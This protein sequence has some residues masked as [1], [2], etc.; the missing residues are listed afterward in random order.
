MFL[1]REFQ[2][3]IGKFGPRQDAA[4]TSKGPP[5]GIRRESEKRGLSIGSL[6]MA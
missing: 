4:A 1:E 2:G 3:Q 6:S 5:Q